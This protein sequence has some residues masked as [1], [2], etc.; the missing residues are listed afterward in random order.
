L[1]QSGNLFERLLQQFRHEANLPDVSP[2][3]NAP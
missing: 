3:R 1:G 2:F